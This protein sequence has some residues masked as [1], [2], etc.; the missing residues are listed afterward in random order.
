MAWRAKREQWRLESPLARAMRREQTEAENRL[1]QRLRRRQ[2][3]GLRF[4]RQYVIDRYIVDFYCAR[5]RLVIEV[6]GGVHDHRAE[7][8]LARERTLESLGLTVLRFSN[9]QVFDSLDAVLQRIA[10]AADH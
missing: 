4:L 3:F 1:W 6:D 7:R 5:E 8:D 2:L 9:T 10:Y